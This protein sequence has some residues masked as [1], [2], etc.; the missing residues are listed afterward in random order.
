MNSIESFIYKH[1]FIFALTSILLLYG[2]VGSME[3]YDERMMEC[4]KSGKDYNEEK[5]VCK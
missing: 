2:V 4:S 5:D 3:Y 1:R